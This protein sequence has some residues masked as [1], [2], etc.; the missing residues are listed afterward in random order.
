MNSGT[1]TNGFVINGAAASDNSGISV[2]SAGDVNGDGLADLIV[3]AYLADPSSGTNAGRSYIIFGS[4]GGAFLMNAINQMGTSSADTLSDSGQSSTIIGGAGPRPQFL[5][6]VKK[7]CPCSFDAEPLFQSLYKKFN[8]KIDFIAVTDADA[9]DAHKWD[10]DLKVPY[11]VVSNPTV[12]IM[13]AYQAPSS[14]YNSLISKEGV[15]VNRW[16]G[17]SKAY[18]TEMNEAI[19][20]L[21]AVPLTPFDV[22]YAPIAGTTG[23]SFTK[24]QEGKSVWDTPNKQLPSKGSILKESAQQP[25]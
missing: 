21:L 13:N 12:D 3:G 19:S 9:K 16:A 20:K 1:Y 8:G 18:L 7:G 10:L 6:F 17:Y 23:C 5:Y 25:K 11:S 2:S 14:V 4:T 24:Y 22:Q 15:I